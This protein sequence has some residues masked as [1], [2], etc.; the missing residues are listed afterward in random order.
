MVQQ[1]SRSMYYMVQ[2]QQR[3]KGKSINVKWKSEQGLLWVE[4]MGQT[5]AMR[6]FLDTSDLFLKLSAS[7]GRGSFCANLLEYVIIGCGVLC[8][9][10]TQT[11]VLK[12]SELAPNDV[13]P[14]VNCHSPIAL[15]Q[16]TREHPKS[17]HDF[18]SS[19]KIPHHSSFPSALRL[20]GCFPGE[21]QHSNNGTRLPF[22]VNAEE[23]FHSFFF[24][25]H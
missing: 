3:Q 7:H 6:G 8:L 24:K 15:K 4:V 22:T 23:S 20:V 14:L 12:T 9:Y 16:G 10:Y 5:V 13:D 11:N 2:Q 17:L 18:I 1:K 19:T 21:I 25:P